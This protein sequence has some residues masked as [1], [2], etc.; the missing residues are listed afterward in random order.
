MPET[1]DGFWL[2]QNIRERVLTTDTEFDT[3]TF[4]QGLASDHKNRAAVTAR[5]P[6]FSMEQWKEILKLLQE[7]RHQAPSGVEFWQR[8]QS[9]LNEIQRRF[10]SPTE[11]LRLQALDTIP[12][13]T[14]YSEP[15]IRYTLSAQNMMALNQIPAAFSFNPSNQIFK[16]WQ[17][18]SGLPGR[19]IFFSANEWQRRMIR[20]T[21][22][23]S[24]KLYAE[25]VP[26][27][28]ALGYGAGNVP[29][30]AMLIAFLCLATTLKSNQLPT[31]VVKNSRREPIFTPLVL[32]AL[33][34]A[35]PELVS[36][37]AVLIWDYQGSAEQDFLLSQADLVLA[38]AGDDT[39]AQ[40]Q[41]QIEKVKEKSNNQHPIRF[42]AHGHKVSFSAISKD[43]LKKGAVLEE[44]N[45]TALLNVVTLLSA[46]D[47][48]FWDQHGCLSSRIHFVEVGGS[49]FFDANQYAAQL[50]TQLRFLEK[51][52][53]RG[54]WPRQ[55]L[56]DRFDR[57]K[58]LERTGKVKVFTSYD[59]E[60][61]IAVD[62]RPL[63]QSA[64][65][66]M[67][68]DCQGRVIIIRPVNDLMEIPDNYLKLLPSSNLQSL[69]VAVGQ[70]PSGLTAPF[71]KFVKEC[72]A[73]GI[74]AVRSVGRGAFP[75]L[76]YSWDGYI[77][78][79]LLHARPEGYFSTIEFDAPYDQM[80]ET[81][82]MIQ[83]R[84][85]E[86]ALV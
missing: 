60:F 64:F 68:N 18:M 66:N 57:Y 41:S 83:Q 48:V 78:L 67:V 42:H 17:A 39:I 56:H 72:C 11:T 4:S 32:N 73:C 25:P 19:T 65:Q 62:Q 28:F 23:R 1:I 82:R 45:N 38:A 74:T 71:L 80:I 27:D 86:S 77:P 44:E 76:S 3:A 12:K 55:L 69:S 50:E 26:L 13:Y 31:V 81:Y 70:N 35:D 58:A 15:M 61:H 9:A 6:R 29:G 34:D 51:A 33:E 22:F 5:W 47:S 37:T 36:T 24:Q 16:D 40:I 43:V 52:I 84:G 59:D 2:P 53:P 63:N 75:Q 30:T 8:F 79:D 14:G 7:N 49:G 20:L 46:L 85:A 10:E 21:S 54:A